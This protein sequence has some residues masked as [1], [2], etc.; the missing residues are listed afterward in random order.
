[1]GREKVSVIIPIFGVE[2]YLTRCIESVICQTYDNLEIILVDDGSQDNCPAICDEYQMKDQRIRVIHKA[3]EGL[4]LTR[5]AG[6]R[7]ATGKYVAFIDSDDWISNDHIDNLYN[8]AEKVDADVVIGSHTR[9]DF[10]GVERRRDIRIS[11]GIYENDKIRYEIV[12]NLIGT[13]PEDKRDVVLEASSCMNLYRM[14]VIRDHQIEFISERCAVAEDLFFNID[15]LCQSQ[16]VVVLNETGYFYFA[17]SDSISTRYS[18]LRFK[19]TLNYYTEL[20]ERL[21]RYE[22]SDNVEQRMQRSFLMKVR[23]AIRHIVLANIRSKKKL[24]EL[25][26]ILENEMLQSVLA[27]YPIEKFVPL[28]HLLFKHMRAKRVV[29]V[30]A[31]MWLRENARKYEMLKKILKKFGI[32]KE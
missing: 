17:N 14:R 1:M 11:E 16:K 32:G 7:I 13:L 6:L 3:N 30:Y 22:F 28:M 26:A 29:I 23:L 9:V 25:K 5:N 15:F 21:V 2:A 24:E 10:S 8:A 20:N 18:P 19:R 12:E 27:T 31:F 4:A